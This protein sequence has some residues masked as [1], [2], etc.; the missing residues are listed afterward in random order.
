MNAYAQMTADNDAGD[1]GVWG[2][3][4]QSATE[5]Y[6]IFCVGDSIFR[7]AAFKAWAA[8]HIGGYKSLWGSY[9]GK[10]ER[11]FIVNARYL[12]LTKKWWQDEETVLLLSPLIYGGRRY[13]SR[14]ATLIEVV[15][16]KS[17]TH[18]YKALG[19]HTDLGFF[20]MVPGPWAI[21]QPCYTFDPTDKSYWV[22]WG[23]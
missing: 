3:S 23:K 12:N 11:S 16:V 22:A 6:V 2:Y 17:D 19:T 20:R 4:S 8:S 13:G 21:K 7:E 18:S 10:T 5:S 1:G 15:T 14:K 9:K